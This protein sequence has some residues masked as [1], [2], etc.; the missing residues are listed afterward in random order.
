MVFTICA[1]ARPLWASRACWF[2]TSA[3]T[4]WGIP[5][6]A[7]AFEEATGCSGSGLAWDWLHTWICEDVMVSVDVLHVSWT[8]AGETNTGCWLPVLTFS[9]VDRERRITISEWC[10]QIGALEVV[11]TWC[12]QCLWEDIPTH[13]H[14]INKIRTVV[15]WIVG[16]TKNWKLLVSAHNLNPFNWQIQCWVVCWIQ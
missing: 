3:K 12:I 14:W 5:P 7:F 13:T 1:E 11:L 15:L 10:P 6:L 4:S 9:P 16:A 8:E 2:L